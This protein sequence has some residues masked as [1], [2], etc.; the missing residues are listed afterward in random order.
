[1]SSNILKRTYKIPSSILSRYQTIPT[2]FQ[3]PSDPQ[4][5]NKPQNHASG[6]QFLSKNLSGF[7]SILNRRLNFSCGSIFNNNTQL[8]F[9]TQTAVE[10]STS[11]G[12][13]VDGIAANQWMILDES[14]SDWKSHASAIAQ[15]V[16]LIK[17]RLQV[18]SQLIMFLIF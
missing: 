4:P 6:F 15:S 3:S 17:K 16:R 14:E 2:I 8:L 11:D 7:S 9:S 13:T 10:P 1:M 12:L 18:N 5:T